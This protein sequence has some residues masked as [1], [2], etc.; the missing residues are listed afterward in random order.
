MR[1]SM[2]PDLYRDFS[3]HMLICLQKCIRNHETKQSSKTVACNSLFSVERYFPVYRSNRIQID[4]T[5]EI[6][7]HLSGVLFTHDWQFSSGV[8]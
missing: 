8:F 7:R 1:L 4:F 3:Q 5:H 2:K 6:F